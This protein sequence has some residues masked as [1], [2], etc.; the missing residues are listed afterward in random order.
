MCL[1]IEQSTI[2]IALRISQ[3]RDNARSI[4]DETNVRLVCGIIKHAAVFVVFPSDRAD[5]VDR[6]ITRKT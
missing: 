3:Q 6:R 5:F 4:S 2:Y 1:L